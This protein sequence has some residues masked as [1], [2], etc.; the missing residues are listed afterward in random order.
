MIVI[1]LLMMVSPIASFA[2]ENAPLRPVAAACSGDCDVCGCSPESRSAG[3]CCC[4]RK[5]QLEARLHGRGQDKP[6]CCRE[7][8]PEEKVVVLSC[9]CP[10]DDDDD[11]A[12]GGSDTDTV[13]IS[14][15]SCPSA[16]PVIALRRPIPPPALVSRRLQP[17]DPP[18]KQS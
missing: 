13:L 9:G 4:S 17:P 5:R 15:H 11:D 12:L 2:K 7:K 1:H 14:R 3:T 16:V 10:C 8:V 18:P 6:A